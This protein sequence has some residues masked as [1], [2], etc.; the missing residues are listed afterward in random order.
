MTRPLLHFPALHPALVQ[1]PVPANVRFLDPGLADPDDPLLWRPDGLPLDATALAGFVREFTRLRSEVK[2]P[3]DLALL[4]DAGSGHFFAATS[5]AVREEMEDTLQPERVVKRRLT[6]A[7]LTL[8]L[9]FLV[10]ANLLELADTADLEG[11]FRS[12][13]AD[14]L[15]LSGDGEQDGEDARALEALVSGGSVLAAPALNEEFGVPWRQILSPF[16]AIAPET[17]GLFATD[18]EMISTWL[19]AGIALAMPSSEEMT[20]LFGEATPAGTV[21][22]VRENG[23]RLLGKTRPN[24]EA[25]WLDLPRTVVILQP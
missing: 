13:L 1:A 10:E 14:S 8:C 24:P 2:N 15:G 22:T 4:A 19:D 20:D 12:A 6:A 23:W 18:P 25:P 17:A 7:Q 21:L 16:W 11:R 9:A 5:F 3:K